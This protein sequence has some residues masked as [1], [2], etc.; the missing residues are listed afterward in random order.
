[1]G[2]PR[3]WVIEYSADGSVWT[4]FGEYTVPD[5]PILSN[6]KAWQ[7]PGP[8]YMSFTLPEDSSMLGK[9]KVYVRMHPANTKAGTPNSYDDGEI[10]S[11]CTSEMN[12]FAI[13]YNK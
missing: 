7:C 11:T 3:Y 8:K 5:F 6:R 1:M 4:E 2:A 12:Y 9:E 10:V 13:R